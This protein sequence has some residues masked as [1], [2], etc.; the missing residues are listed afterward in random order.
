MGESSYKKAIA[1]QL[2]VVV[3]WRLGLGRWREVAERCGEVR[4]LWG[5]FDE[6]RGWQGA[7]F[8]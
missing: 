3:R 1:E 2:Q 8:R 5:L 7:D 4:R 6:E